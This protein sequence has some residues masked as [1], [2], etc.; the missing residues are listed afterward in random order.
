MIET[1]SIISL[2][3]AGRSSEAFDLR[4]AGEEGGV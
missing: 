4:D 3:P 1:P 2:A